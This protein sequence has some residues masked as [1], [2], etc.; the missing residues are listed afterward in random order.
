MVL[1]A[2]IQSAWSEAMRP[3]LPSV[4]SPVT[5]VKVT[6]SVHDLA[7]LLVLCHLSHGKTGML[8]ISSI[9]QSLAMERERRFHWMVNCLPPADDS[10]APTD[11]SM[12]CSSNVCDSPSDFFKNTTGCSSH[13]LSALNKWSNF[14][15]HVSNVGCLN[16]FGS[17]GLLPASSLFHAIIDAGASLFV[18]PHQADFID[19]QE[20][21]GTVLKGLAS[22]AAIAG[23]WM[24]EWHVEVGGKILHLWLH[25]IHIPTAEQQLL[26]SQQIL[27]ELFPFIKEHSIW[28]HH[29]LLNFP[30]GSLE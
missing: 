21:S 19:Y 9:L 3:S 2:V 1:F 25:A 18:S 12:P 5:F 10:P 8:A 16:I 20:Q 22:C 30:C 7:Y 29:V 17:I 23:R 11:P 27:Q 13:I 28:D 4:P 14:Y 15:M 26:C 6:A 24:L